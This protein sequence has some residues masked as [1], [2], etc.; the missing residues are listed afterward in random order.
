MALSDSVL[1]IV[2]RDNR[3]G[4]NGEIYYKYSTDNGVNWGTDMRLTNDSGISSHPG[5]AVSGLNVYVI[6]RD[7]RDGNTEIY[8]KKS[9]DG[10]KSWGNDIRITNDWA[11]SY[12][13]SV[14]VLGLMVHIVWED[15]RDG[16]SEIYYKCSTDG[17]I[18]WSKDTRLTNNP[19]VSNLPASVVNDSNVYIVWND[20]RDGNNEIYYKHSFNAGLSWESDTRLTNAFGNS[21]W[22]SLAASGKSIH[23]IWQDD[24]NGSGEIFY[25]YSKNGGLN[26]SADTVLVD[27]L[28]TISEYP[29]VAL[30]GSKVHLIW[31]DM[32]DGPNG[33]VYYKSNPA[34]KPVSII[35]N[36]ANGSEEVIIFPNPFSENIN[37]EI[38]N[39]ENAEINIY[40]Q[41][42]KLIRSLE[43]QAYNGRRS[44][45]R[46]NGLDKNNL[47]VVG[48]VY[49]FKVSLGNKLIVK[50]IVVL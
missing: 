2:W 36:L 13:P 24:R 21:W 17:G 22:P 10:G 23:I 48:G 15:Q 30:T 47:R 32:R 1:H 41:T 31:T 42:G 9:T 46:W 20:Y 27:N 43:C 45:V 19:Y 4:A 34:T 26:W 50:K 7:D 8:L 40:D 3:N 44:F 14:S 29:A 33:E 49:Y 28:T 16:N 35:N 5:I 39:A 12:N 37:I 25:K 6:W 11:G 18:N 38:A